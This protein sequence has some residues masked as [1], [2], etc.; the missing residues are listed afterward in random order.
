MCFSSISS[1]IRCACTQDA[2]TIL[3]DC[4]E[5]WRNLVMTEL[6]VKI[7]RSTAVGIKR[8]PLKLNY[9]LVEK[10]FHFKTVQLPLLLLES[11]LF[12]ILKDIRLSLNWTRALQTYSFRCLI[13]TACWVQVFFAMWSLVKLK[14]KI[15]NT[16]GAEFSSYI[17]W[18]K[19]WVLKQ[20]GLRNENDWESRFNF[21]KDV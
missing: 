16:R 15:N 4:M 19:I 17:I 6:D 12:N 18:V 11:T 10:A 14:Q 20:S 7:D 2:S 8:C 3:T 21:L 9:L 5:A 13:T 1:L